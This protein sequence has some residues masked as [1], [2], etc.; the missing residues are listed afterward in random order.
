MPAA[1]SGEDF[2]EQVPGDPRRFLCR[3][4]TDFQG[5][6]TRG[7]V[8]ILRTSKHGHLTSG[9]HVQAVKTKAQREASANAEIEASAAPVPAQL[10]FM[11]HI[12][13]HNIG[14]Q[15]GNNSPP[16]LFAGLAI[17]DSHLVD[18]DGDI[19]LFSAGEDTSVTDMRHRHQLETQ[20]DD[21]NLAGEN[22]LFTIS[23]ITAE[24]HL[25][26]E[27]SSVMQFVSRMQAL[28][29]ES[30]EED[31]D[32]EDTHMPDQREAGRWSPHGSK[33]SDPTQVFMLDLIDNLPR[34][35]LSDDH[36][37][38][39]MWVMRECGT[40]NVPSFSTLRK[41]QAALTKDFNA[42]PKRH[43]SSLG[44]H[45]YTNHPAK[46][47]AL[48]YG[49][50][51]VCPL[52]HPYIEVAG[53]VTEMLQAAKYDEAD[54]D[55]HSPMWADWKN[56][57]TMHRHYYIKELAQLTDGSFL[58]LLRWVTV[59]SVVHV[60]GLEV[61]F[62]EELTKFSV[63]RGIKQHPAS[64]LHWNVLDLEKSL[65]PFQFDQYSPVY[66]MP[67]PLRKVAN[68]RPMF[69]L[70]VLPWS[71]DVSGNVSKQYN[72]H[73]N[74]YVINANLPHRTTSQE[75]FVR[76][77]STSPHAS[78]SEQFAALSEDFKADV[79]HDAYHCELEQEILF[80]IIP[81]VLPADN[82]QQSET[83]SHIGVNGNF[84]CRRDLTGGTQ[85]QKESDELYHKLYEIGEPRTTEQTIQAI[86]WQIWTACSGDKE[87]LMNHYSQSGVKDKISQYWIEAL[88]AR[89]KQLR[90]SRIT[91]TETRD[92]RL[93]DPALQDEARKV[94][95]TTIGCEIQL[96]L[97]N[98]VIQQPSESYL[99][100]KENDP[101]RNDLR[102]GDHYNVLLK[103]RG[104][105]PHRDTP[106]EIL[107]TWLLGNEKYVWHDTNKDW[108]KKKDDL[109]AIRL[110]SAS[111]DG[112]T[113]PR[114]R[115]EYLVKYKNSLIGKHFKTLQQLGVFHI[116][117]LCS[118]NLFNLWK[119]SGELGAVIWYPEISNMEAYLADLQVL[120]NNVLDRWAE[121]DPRRILVKLKLHVLT[122]LVEDVRRFGPAILYS[123]E[124][125]ECFNAIFRMCSILSN[126]LAPSH[127]IAVTIA[128]M[129]RFKH[130]VSGG[131]W[132]AS[133]GKY[134]QAGEKVRTFL[135]QNPSLQQRLGWADGSAMRPGFVKLESRT[136]RKNSTWLEICSSIP[137]N[138]TFSS[139]GTWQACKYLV[140]QAEDPCREG[141]WV[142][143]S[144][145][146]KMFAGRI[147]KILRRFSATTNAMSAQKVV[148]IIKVYDVDDVKDPRFNMPVLT[149]SRYNDGYV[150]AEPKDV[151]FIFNA[152]HDCETGGC[153]ISNEAMF[154]QQERIQTTTPRKTIS[155]AASDRYIL[156]M[157]ALHNA[158]LIRKV[159]PRHLT[160]PT[161]YR[162]DQ[163]VFHKELA[164]GLRV[165]GP[166][167][168]AASQAKAKATRERNKA[169]KAQQG[170]RGGPGRALA[171]IAE[172]EGDVNGGMAGS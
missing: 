100:L 91:D 84:N 158:H 146:D 162:A 147:F 156:N 64:S 172:E 131:W 124:I 160:A 109:F 40:P 6:S 108:D 93:K 114:P 157:H 36:L 154:Y 23:D 113:I 47:L 9:K 56:L 17:E 8:T 110:E 59:N 171:R 26:T 122:H 75:Y 88:I 78:S 153:T 120:V 68:G 65:G 145:C 144:Q 164:A 104:I 12:N 39:F 170:N 24:M 137:L 50:P 63:K 125:F 161:P 102:E 107:H 22:S 16:D 34:L 72:A 44:N 19:L 139:D 148:V 61:A 98:W 4:C 101:R 28:G 127:D 74:V 134:I 130:M 119:A 45:F 46:L 60:Q 149:P 33:T 95:K 67:N 169:A 118:D 54:F 27:D 133:S 138:A 29:I 10:S 37:K 35:R 80:Q 11:D 18:A 129:E 151:S 2:L 152:Q 41:I 167:K 5:L 30:E 1:R 89:S 7:A 141:S 21:V 105:D 25:E 163:L 57:S 73:T 150:V 85:V 94:M 96:E 132:K 168:R 48:D 99:R 69:R 81:H 142:F 77:C 87:A 66:D 13:Q 140:S 117:G 58:L 43:T 71:D 14:E 159:L 112:L 165:T 121:V 55:E 123:T 86:R 82:P 53:P 90:A 32:N 126:H 76:F 111:I 103:T 38:A 15:A 128:D 42:G 62:D 97:W 92:A 143:F 20:L 115:A 83:S 3:I 52:I 79:W 49:N 166:A 155:H 51:L 135:L 116:H 70:R 136:R 31:E 106:V